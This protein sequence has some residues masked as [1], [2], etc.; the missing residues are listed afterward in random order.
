MYS[1][2]LKIRVVEKIQLL[3]TKQSSVNAV[4]NGQFLSNKVVIRR[5]YRAP[6]FDD[7]TFAKP[8]QYSTGLVHVLVNGVPVIA[9]GKHTGATPGRAIRGSGWTGHQK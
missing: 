5:A 9:D 2:K 8:H 6:W 1:I 4:V 3:P 7:A